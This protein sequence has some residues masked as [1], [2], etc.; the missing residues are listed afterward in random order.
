[1]KHRCVSC[2]P[3]RCALSRNMES[4]PSSGALSPVGRNKELHPSYGA[5]SPVKGV[6]SLPVMIT[7]RHSDAVS[8]DTELSPPSIALSPVEGK[9]PPTAQHCAPWRRRCERVRRVR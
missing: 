8:R 5:L 2:R 6:L 1:M 3:R 9:L 7:R 4:P